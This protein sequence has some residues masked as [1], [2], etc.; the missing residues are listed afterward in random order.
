M[1]FKED[2]FLYL[3]KVLRMEKLVKQGENPVSDI[4]I[5]LMKVRIDLRLLWFQIGVPSSLS[6]WKF[7]RKWISTVK[8]LLKI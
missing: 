1:R 5:K 6:F 3:E 2:I 7:D 4:K 8:E